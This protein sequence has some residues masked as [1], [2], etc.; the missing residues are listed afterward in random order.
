[1]LT[2]ELQQVVQEAG[3][4]IEKQGDAFLQDMVSSRLDVLEAK[5]KVFSR[6]EALLLQEKERLE[7]DKRDL[8][9]K[10]LHANI[11]PAA[12]SA[13]A[14]AGVAMGTAGVGNAGLSSTGG[15]PGMPAYR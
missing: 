15:L 2:E 12:S 1:M 10:Q 14:L 9:L 13:A 7:I 4:V 6:V 3:D 11:H 8:L 5:I